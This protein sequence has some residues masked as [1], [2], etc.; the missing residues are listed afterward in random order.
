MPKKTPKTPQFVELSDTESE[1][2]QVENKSPEAH[3]DNNAV[4]PSFKFDF[5]DVSFILD[6]C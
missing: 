4:S 1:A 3:M 6:G 5:A 2:G